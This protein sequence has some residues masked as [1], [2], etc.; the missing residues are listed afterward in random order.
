MMELAKIPQRYFGKTFDDYDV[1]SSNRDAVTYAKNVLKT[2]RGA[3]FYGERGT[4]KTFLA[5]I[6]A[7]EFLRAG[8]TVVFEKVTGLLGEI[9]D[10]FNGRG[11]FSEAQI[12]DAA[13]KADL[14]VLD[15]MGMEKPT[16][17]AGATLCSIIDARYD[18]PRLT[19]IITSNEPIET[20][21]NGLDHAVD[22]KNCNGSRIH[23][24]CMEI[25]KPIL[26]NGVSRRR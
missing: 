23:D 1:D 5:S 7:Q 15:D 4:G 17:F 21:C 24:R 10:T 14:L 25:C 8:K 9:R 11:K 16:M 18:R 22:G 26:L 6:I 19:T 2:R 20:V 13:S 3:Y 12:M